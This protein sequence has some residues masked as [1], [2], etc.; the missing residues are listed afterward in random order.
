MQDA[1]ADLKR[2][3]F[4]SPD[5]HWAWLML[6]EA[7]W[8]ADN[9]PAALHAAET[10]L[11]LKS[12]DWWAWFIKGAVHSALQ[13]FQRALAAFDRCLS[14]NPGCRQAATWKAHLLAALPPEVQARTT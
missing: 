9:L 2:A 8:L 11:S 1:I 4:L 13:D 6:A 10:A 7:L 3:V 12:S 14:L 5:F